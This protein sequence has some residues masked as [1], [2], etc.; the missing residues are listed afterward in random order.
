MSGPGAEPGAALRPRR[1][2][3]LEPLCG[4]AAE[5]PAR[6]DVGPQAPSHTL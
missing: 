3:T 6:C 2:V 1:R 4:S 5:L